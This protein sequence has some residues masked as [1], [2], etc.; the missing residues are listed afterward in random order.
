MSEPDDLCARLLGRA[1]FCED[2]RE[3]KTPALLREAIERIR[4]LEAD[5]TEIRDL[6]PNE[7]DAYSRRVFKI[8][9][10]AVEPD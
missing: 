5:L 8:A 3:V 1:L 6:L 4:S 2:R 9:A 7:P 10:N